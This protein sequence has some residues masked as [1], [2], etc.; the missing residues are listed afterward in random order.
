MQY[1]NRLCNESGVLMAA[2]SDILPLSST[3]IEENN[4]SDVAGMLLH[5]ISEARFSGYAEV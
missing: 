2:I 4:Y 5:K 1:H 3:P